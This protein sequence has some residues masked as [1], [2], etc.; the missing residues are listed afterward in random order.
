MCFIGIIPNI[1]TQVNNS[2]KTVLVSWL[3]V[4]EADEY[5]I[6]VTGRN[7]RNQVYSIIAE[8][9]NTKAEFE[10]ENLPPEQNYTICV[11]GFYRRTEQTFS[12]CRDILT[13]PSPTPLTT[14]NETAFAVTSSIA[15]TCSAPLAGTLGSI[16][17]LLMLLLVVAGVGLAYPR[18]IR[19]RVKDVRYLSK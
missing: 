11:S 6:R 17:A 18:C 16:I 4:P 15:A 14:A 7:A 1:A 19:P 13:T 10:Y 12:S 8:V 2:D 9:S 3:W 5:N